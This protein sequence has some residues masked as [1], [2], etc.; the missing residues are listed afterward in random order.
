M[1]PGFTIGEEHVHATFKGLVI[2]VDIDKEVGS[3][4]TQLSILRKEASNEI[5]VEVTIPT[6]YCSLPFGRT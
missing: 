6:H 1:N 4:G 3:N 2:V 5:D